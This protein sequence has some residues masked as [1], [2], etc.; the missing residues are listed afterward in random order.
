MSKKLLE[1]AGRGN[2]V[3]IRSMTSFGL[4]VALKKC[5]LYKD[6][7]DEVLDLGQTGRM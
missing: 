7:K 6:V 3:G 5:T 2:V 4:D 1:G